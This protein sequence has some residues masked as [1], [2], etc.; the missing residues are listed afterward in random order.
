MVFVMSVVV[1]TV[2]RLVLPVILVGLGVG[3]IGIVFI[4][5]WV[6]RKLIDGGKK[7]GV[8]K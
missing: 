6:N 4:S 1:P 2:T 5:E 8:R 3:M 7:K